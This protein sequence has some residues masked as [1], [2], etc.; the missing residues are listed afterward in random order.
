MSSDQRK[1]CAFCTSRK[2]SA[3][4]RLPHPGSVLRNLLGKDPTARSVFS[5]PDWITHP[6][7][8]SEM[9]YRTMSNVGDNKVN[10]YIQTERGSGTSLVDYKCTG[11]YI[12]IKQRG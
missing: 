8:V 2:A 5:A 1:G 12:P 4:A 7:S 3:P 6:N 11:L 9:S 10:T